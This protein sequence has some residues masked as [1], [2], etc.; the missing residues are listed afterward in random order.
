M[1]NLFYWSNSDKLQSMKTR[2]KAFF[3]FLIFLIGMSVFISWNYAAATSME[4]AVYSGVIFIDGAVQ[5][6]VV[7]DPPLGMPGDSLNLQVS[8]NNKDNITHTPNIL[9]Q[10]PSH[11]SLQ[12]NIL[13]A[14][15]TH[16]FQTN[17]LTWRP[18]LAANGG[19][20]QFVLPLRVDTID[21]TN[22]EQII[23]AVL[24]VNNADQQAGTSIW[25]GLPPQIDSIVLP[26]QIS[27][28]LPV[29]LRGIT[30]GPGPIAQSWSLG[31]GRQVNVN[32][33]V[34]VFPAV[35]VYE[36]GLEVSNAVGSSF[37]THQ[38][39]V[40]PHPASQFKV[41][42]VTLGLG[43]PVTFINESGGQ[44]PLSYNWDFGDGAVSSEL[45]PVHQY[46]TPGV[47]NVR[48][49]VENEY[50]RSEAFWP[51]TV[52]QPPL[53][54]MQIGDLVKAGQPLLGQAVGDESVTEFLWD[55]GDG[56]SETGAQITHVYHNT[57]DFYVNLTAVN[58]F[59]VTQL[60][61]WVHVD[62]GALSVY[63]PIVMKAAESSPEGS[64]DGDPFALALD[65]VEL[66]A[67]FV[68]QPMELP[69]GTSQAEALLIYINEARRQ[70]NLSPLKYVYELSVAAQK[71][72]TDMS[73]YHYTGHTGS[74]GSFPAE[75]L[76]W[77][78]YT[79]AY[80]G[81]AT[82]WGFEHAYQAVEFWI[83]SPAHRRII[84][85]QWAT[86]VGVAFTT[87]Y[88][89]PNV[90]YWTAEFGN[91]FGEVTSP[92]L[93][94]QTPGTGLEVLNT[95]LVTYSWNWPMPLAPGE[96]FGVY[97][98]DED[99]NETS[100]GVMDAPTHGT[101][102]R[103]QGAF[104]DAVERSGL[105]EWVVRLESNGA[106]RLESESRGMTV[107]WNP[108]LPTPTPE[109]EADIETVTPTAT[110]VFTPTPMRMHPTVTPR[111]TEPPPPVLVTATAVPT[112]AP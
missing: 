86:D 83:N 68:M 93:R 88:S 97:V 22:P 14:G 18:V 65:P 70:F 49:I 95:D 108:D 112:S 11:L 98:T 105:F 57:G 78:G 80:A 59:G 75:R 73:V 50:G 67:P 17:S 102:Y 29:Q 52:G 66:D 7:I 81:E 25:I 26:E 5:L 10:L 28:G 46:Q 6:Q 60:G 37:V 23:T 69:A 30:S 38:I 21:I 40:V 9:I 64:A 42:D 44:Q 58:D 53:A 16:N 32:N 85:N 33:P 55:M 12:S 84:L 36:L 34:V 48:L 31:D 45:N 62:P 109:F 96:Q 8:A 1:R 24:N 72:T 89:A 2:A 111:P 56:S 61:R 82:A 35:G 15:A 107:Y 77:N 4:N 47:Y 104:I 99:G 27:V 92:L 43:Q 3:T 19:V 101:L 20:Q 87:D 103:F 63:L 39:T 79:G 41:D 76:L 54:D 13:P 110:A 106:N 74:D 90:W 100:L 94:V 51:V 71:H 91:G